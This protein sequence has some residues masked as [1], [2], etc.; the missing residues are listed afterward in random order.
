M[1][2]RRLA[3]L[4][5][6]L[7]M[8]PLAVSD[9]PPTVPG[10]FIAGSAP[11]KYQASVDGSVVHSGSSSASLAA[12][13]DAQGFEYGTLM[14]V[15]AARPYIGKRLRFSVFIRTAGVKVGAAAWM[16][17]DGHDGQVLAFDN[18]SDRGWF[19]ADQSWSRADIVLDVLTESKVISFGVLL[20]GDGMVWIDSA[21]LEPVLRHIATTGAPVTGPSLPVAPDELPPSPLNLGFEATAEM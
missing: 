9:Q 20:K 2:G 10:W 13:T 16:R 11:A 4:V 7:F 6:I 12:I 3:T 19:R 15:A 14:Q 18:M 5:A 8:S 1:S 21:S 17:I